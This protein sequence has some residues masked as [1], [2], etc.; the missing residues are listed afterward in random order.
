MRLTRLLMQYKHFGGKARLP[1]TPERVP[2]QEI[3]PLKLKN[4]GKKLY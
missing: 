2:F 3:L 4:R 1:Q